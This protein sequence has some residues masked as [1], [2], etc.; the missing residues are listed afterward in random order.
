MYKRYDGAWCL[1]REPEM[2]DRFVR[3]YKNQ[4]EYQRDAEKLMR[5]GF[6]PV[7]QV[8]GD[9][10]VTATRLLTT[11]VLAFAWKKGGKVTVTW[12]RAA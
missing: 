8:G 4:K 7:A 3:T 12:E 1:G 9:S 6:V 2:D 5:S 10:R 11:G